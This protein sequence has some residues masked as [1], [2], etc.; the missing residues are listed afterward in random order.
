M[1]ILTGLDAGLKLL[2]TET[3]AEDDKLMQYLPKAKGDAAEHLAQEQADMWIQLSQQEA[4]LRNMA[5]VALMSQLTHAHGS[6]CSVTRSHGRL[7]TRTHMPGKTSSRRF[8]QTSE[9]GSA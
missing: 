1:L 5:L 6:A 3:Q 2:N 4:F 8:G 7:A 9:H